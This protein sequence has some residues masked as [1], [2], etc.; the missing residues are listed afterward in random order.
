M[1]QQKSQTHSLCRFLCLLLIFTIVFLTGAAAADSGSEASLPS[2]DLPPT[3][4]ADAASSTQDKNIIWYVEMNAQDAE[5]TI[6]FTAS[7]N[8]AFLRSCEG[9][10]TSDELAYNGTLSTAISMNTS[11][12]TL[13]DISYTYTGRSYTGSTTISGVTLSMGYYKPHLYDTLLEC[14]FLSSWDLNEAHFTISNANDN[15]LIKKWVIVGDVNRDRSVDATDAQLA[16]QHSVDNY[17]SDELGQIAADVNEDGIIDAT[18]AMLINQYSAGLIDSFWNDYSTPSTLPTGETEGMVNGGTYLFQNAYNA[19][20]LAYSS[21]ASGS[22]LSQVRFSPTSSSQQFIVVYKGSGE[23]ELQ[24]KNNTSLVW[25][26][27]SSNELI[28]QTRT[29]TASS[30]QRWYIIKNSDDTYQ[31]INKANTARCLT[32]AGDSSTVS[33]APDRVKIGTST[34]GNKWRLCRDVGRTSYDY[35]DASFAVRY[36]TYEILDSDIVFNSHPV[37]L[38]GDARAAATQA[39][40]TLLGVNIKYSSVLSNETTADACRAGKGYSVTSTAR[41]TSSAS[42]HAHGTTEEGVALHCTDH[43]AQFNDFT[44]TRSLNGVNDRINTLWSGAYLYKEGTY[45]QNNRSYNTTC[46]V[47][48]V[49]NGS[50]HIHMINLSSNA[51]EAASSTKEVYIHEMS[52]AWGAQDHYHDEANPEN[53]DSGK[54]GVCSNVDCKAFN[55]AGFP[56]SNHRSSKCMMNTHMWWNDA[57]SIRDL[58]CSDCLP[59]MQAYVSNYYSGEE[60]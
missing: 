46:L 57:D 44:S 29:T 58:Y 26:K 54:R 49:P 7:Y 19:N 48:G 28:L 60:S 35:Y 32:V 37:R 27:S 55:E 41:C 51:W 36:E 21:L 4:S 34:V 12:S 30:A 11:N 33:S 38:I 14:R 53:C 18:D 10:R 16:L 25:A 20:G 8:A 2:A 47:N 39:F 59:E 31:L 52:H 43:W 45:T 13:N 23:Y 22:T 5:R 50:N 24:S 42:G 17:I 40:G 1:Q 3:L 6:S 56:A 9:L 15:A